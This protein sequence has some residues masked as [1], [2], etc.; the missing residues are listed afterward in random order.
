[1]KHTDEMILVGRVSGLFGVKGWIKLHSDT[2]PRENI[3]SYS[4][5]YLECKDE[6]GAQW[7]AVK[8][9]SGKK[10][11]KSIIAHLA[12]CSDRNAAEL[13]VGLRVAIKQEQLA[14]TAEG[15]YYWS[16]LIGLKVST[17]EKVEL[18]V[19]TE[20]MET[21]ANDVFVVRAEEDGQERLLPFIHG[22]VIKEIDLEQA[23]MTVDWDP[24]F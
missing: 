19:I 4:P 9:L 23:C 8:L 14:T 21:G 5:L 16:D 2:G 7:Q 22:D 15:E 24:E 17:L 3:L 20:M 11:G 1:M 10:Q 12:D 18:G 6:S 13:L